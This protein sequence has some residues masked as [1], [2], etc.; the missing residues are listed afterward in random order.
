MEGEGE[1]EE[2]KKKTL[3]LIWGAVRSISIPPT[4]E[5]GKHC[6][7]VHVYNVYSSVSYVSVPIENMECKIQNHLAPEA[8]I[9]CLPYWRLMICTKQGVRMCMVGGSG[10]KNHLTSVSLCD[11]TL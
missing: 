9:F 11:V 4:K 6:S 7:R 5:F 10:V 3:F 2:E 8:C 1:K